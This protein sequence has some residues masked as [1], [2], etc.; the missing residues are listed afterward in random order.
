ATSLE[1]GGATTN[2][3]SLRLTGVGGLGAKVGIDLA[4][5]NPVTY[6]LTN[7]AARIE[8]TDDNWSA[9]INFM[10]KV[11][12]SANDALTSR[13]FIRNDGNIGIGTNAPVSALHVIGTV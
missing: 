4:T 3:P 11:P 9:G 13:L 1:I 6:G 8:A 12:G 7:A 10:T 5:Y 2:G